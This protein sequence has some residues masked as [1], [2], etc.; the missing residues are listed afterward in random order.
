MED[1]HFI[2]K[3][4]SVDV[5]WKSQLCLLVLTSCMDLNPHQQRKPFLYAKQIKLIW[6]DGFLNQPY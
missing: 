1:K 4:K 3:S 2:K 6:K 5:A